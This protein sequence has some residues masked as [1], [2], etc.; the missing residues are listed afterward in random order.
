MWPAG[1]ATQPSYFPK[2]SGLQCHPRIPDKLGIQTPTLNFW[3]T[4]KLPL[5]YPPKRASFIKHQ[6]LLCFAR[7][8]RKSEYLSE[9]LCECLLGAGWATQSA[10]D[11]RISPR[12][13]WFPGQ[14]QISGPSL[15]S[16]GIGNS[17]AYR[18]SGL[19][20]TTPCNMGDI[21]D[22]ICNMKYIYNNIQYTIY[23]M[24]YTIYNVEKTANNMED[25]Y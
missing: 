4:P 6:Y 17:N 2:N 22:I 14:L 18:I 12:G 20:L 11:F 25:I 7:P 9:Y 5:S 1:M 8:H 23:I 24:Q 16:R 19:P 10:K 3:V 15:I 21:K 13:P